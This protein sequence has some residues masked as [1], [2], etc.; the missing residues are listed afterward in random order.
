VDR[1]N[2]RKALSLLVELR[3][4]GAVS[5]WEL[6][7]PMGDQTTTLH[8]AGAASDDRLLIV[9]GRTSGAIV[10]ISEELVEIGGEQMN[11]LRTV[12]REGAELAR[13]AV[14]RDSVLYDELSRLNNELANLQRQ[15]AKQNVE[16]ERLNEQKNE[17]LGMAAHD[18]RNP[19][20][21]IGAYSDFVI[22]EAADVLSDE[23][24]GFLSVIRRSSEFMLRLV[25]DLLDFAEI[26]AGQL[27]LDLHSVGL[28]ALVERNVALNQVLAA[29][30]QIELVI[31][32]DGGISDIWVDGPKIE[33]ILNNLIGNA[34]KFSP[35]GSTVQVRLDCEND[36]AVISVKDEGPGIPANERDRLFQPFSRTSVKGTGGE[37]STGLGLAIVRRIVRGHG[38]E[39]WAESE[40]EQGATFYVSLPIQRKETGCT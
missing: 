6:N 15:L 17:F 33:Q 20:S 14:E 24:M 16:L 29:R 5:G 19:L 40:L 22:D 27:Q 1:A 35:P 18:L 28:I 30:K 21:I 34:V 7:V 12:M 4:Q 38:G 10:R 37:K 3:A 13:S 9:G 39:I 11:A 23:H 36:R 31:S 32:H 25:D 26:E 2:L 8:F